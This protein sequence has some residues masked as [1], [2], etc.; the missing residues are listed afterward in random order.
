[1]TPP[2]PAQVPERDVVIAGGGIGGLTTALSLHAVGIRPLVLESSRRISPLGVGIN[3]QPAAVRELHELGLADELAAI[4][5]PAVAHVFTDRYGT[6]RYSDPR[7]TAA[8]YRW[9]QYSVHRGDLQMMLLRTVRE[10]I[11]P[12][13][14]RTGIRVEDFTQT[15]DAVHVHALDRTTDRHERHA[16]RVLVA[17]DGIHSRLRARL[18]PAQGPLRWSGVTMWRG[19]TETDAFPP[20]NALLLA[21]D[22]RNTQFV[23]Y[24]ISPAA[25]ARGR[26]L[27]NWVCAVPTGAP[28]P[29]A[30]DALWNRPGRLADVLPYYADWRFDWTDL[31]ALLAGAERIL[32]YPMA[33]RDPLPS[34][35]EGRVTLLGDAA[36]PAYPSGANGGSQ[37]V[38]DARVLAHRLATEPDPVRALA[39]YED[40][41]KAPTAAV[42][43]ANRE[44]DRAARA[45]TAA[46]GP[47]ARRDLERAAAAH[48]RA[49]GGAAALN[50]RPS[51]TPRA[52]P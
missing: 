20:G 10:R 17:A 16:A 21:S 37:A 30:G 4:G 52:R 15:P 7:G 45:R 29:L 42:V 22:E 40:E 41:R 35:G 32:E 47:D 3:L 39:A 19:V 51:Y 28:G 50:S 44:M 9:P 43:L 48:R 49:A 24:Q 31:P 13:A 26:T 1:M 18:H 34:W 23:A 25:L 14:V 33:D 36:H 27:L 6:V 5:V 38:L 2:R 8:G 11:G 12:E 46:G